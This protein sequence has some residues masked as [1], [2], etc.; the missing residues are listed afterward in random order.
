MMKRPDPILSVLGLCAAL[1]ACLPLGGCA[2]A[3]KTV[4]VSPLPRDV[5]GNM[6]P[7]EGS[8]SVRYT[9]NIKA[10]PVNRYVDPANRGIMHEG[11]TIYRVETSPRW[12]LRP[13][14]PVGVPMGP[15][16]AVRN[17]ASNPSPLPGELNAELARQKEATRTVIAQGQRLGS[18][19]D[20][21]QGALDQ[22]AA[23][24][25]EQ[26]KLQA[27]LL[28]TQNPVEQLEKDRAEKGASGGTDV[29]TPTPL[30]QTSPANGQKPESFESP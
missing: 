27:E 18:S 26:R 22:T 11:H 23:T 7:S 9:E 5:P 17:P 20:R 25:E 13:N 16:V 24:A 10:Y 15:R 6:L 4:V 8:E 12:N 30:P 2:S 29:P 1:A 3:H 28:K 21:L 19:I 14:Q